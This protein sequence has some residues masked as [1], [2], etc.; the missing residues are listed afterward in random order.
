[1]AMPDNLPISETLGVFVG[2]AGFDWLSD[3]NA[4]PLTALLAAIAAGGVIYLAR[5]MR[6]RHRA[7]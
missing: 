7:D 5:R 2:V 6:D 3:G 4:N 1:M